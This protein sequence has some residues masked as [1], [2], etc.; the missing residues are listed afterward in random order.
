MGQ[1]ERNLEK[2][3]NEYATAEGWQHAKL[4]K[5]KRG[6]PDQIYFGPLGAVLI[7]E[8]KLPGQKPRPQQAAVHR[9]L[10]ALGH[11]V[12]VVTSFSQFVSLMRR[13]SDLAAAL[14]EP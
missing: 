2:K 7:V 3:C 4:E 12:S 10:F 5:G 14:P 9:R 1:L 8:F 11:P 6:W 13:A